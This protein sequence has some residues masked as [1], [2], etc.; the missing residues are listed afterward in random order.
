MSH[1]M[2][3]HQPEQDGDDRE[4]DALPIARGRA[5]HALWRWRRRGLRQRWYASIAVFLVALLGGGLLAYVVVNQMV[6]DITETTVA[7]REQSLL[8]LALNTRISELQDGAHAIIGYPPGPEEGADPAAFRDASSSVEHV[9]QQAVTAFT[10]PSARRHVE[11]SH[12][13]W[14]QTKADTEPFVDD[15]GPRDPD[16][17]LAA[18]ASVGQAM[19]E[20]SS[21][22]GVLLDEVNA[23]ARDSIGSARRL[24]RDVT[25]TLVATF[26]LACL[27]A[28]RFAHRLS[29]LVL[30]PLEVLRAGAERLAAGELDHRIALPRHDEL[31]MLA[32]AFNDMADAVGSTHKSLAY[33]AGHD[34]LTGLAN[35]ASFLSAVDHALSKGDGDAVSVLFIDL[36]DFKTVNDVDG[37]AAGD[38]LLQHVAERL[39]SCVRGDDVV[40]RLGGDEFAIMLCHGPDAAPAVDMAE[41]VLAAM[42]APFSLH[43]TTTE[44]RASVGVATLPG[45]SG[46]DAT[47]AVRQ[48]DI[49]MYTAKGMGKSCFQLFSLA[50][51]D[52]MLDRLALKADLRGAGDR[53]ELL[54]EYQ[55]VYDL[56][57]SVIVGVEALVRWN[58][59]ARG[60][61]AP[62]DFIPLA[63]QCGEIEHIDRFV[64]HTASRQVRRW[65]WARPEHRDLWVSVN[66]SASHV[67][68]DRLVDDVETVLA[69]SGLAP[70]SLVIE[71]TETTL[72]KNLD[73]EVAA[74][75]SALRQ[76]GVRIAIDDFGTGFSS[77]SYLQRLPVDVLKVDRTFVSGAASTQHGPLLQTIIALGSNLG[78]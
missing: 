24:N 30:S 43:A 28:V 54:V 20:A 70:A 56:R 13:L 34:P 11:E 68:G 48:A 69:E 5:R 40:A 21:R 15:A 29:R 2:T 23:E 72:V 55:P 46:V 1:H 18:H 16:A 63:E 71:L 67:D 64:L 9:F 35:R 4:D 32:R 10:T 65:Q 45:G 73:D 44:V 33:Q 41:R 59:P 57:T 12:A 14:Q 58:H 36:D 51:H 3:S 26:A 19:G 7:V 42:E 66:I 78:L 31:G 62:V 53:G 52:E 47:E 50:L 17:L 60:L 38:Q 27:L 74:R 77:L 39:R 37:H 22:L 61:L 8:A 75:L 76:R 25:I 6:D 49:A